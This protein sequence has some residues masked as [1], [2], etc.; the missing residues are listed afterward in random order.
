MKT[1]LVTGGAGYVGSHTV[2]ALKKESCKVVIYDNLVYGH[3][4]ATQYADDFIEGDLSDR[5]KLKKVF[6]RYVFDGVLHFAAYAYVGESVNNPSK[7]YQNNVVNSLNLLDMIIKNGIR[8]IVFSSSCTVYG[9][10]NEIPV[11]EGHPLNPISPYGKTKFM[12]EHILQDYQKAYGLNYAALRYFN[13]AGAD[14]EG[15][16]YED[17]TPETHLIPLIL[18]VASGEKEFL[19]IY[20]NDYPTADGSCVRDYVHVDD[21]ASAHI[22]ALNFL[23]K[24]PGGHIFNLGYGKGY[25]VKEIIEIA[26]KVTK[27]TI[28]VRIGPR[29]DGDPAA[30]IADNKKAL[31]ILSWSPQRDDIEMIVKSA[32]ENSQK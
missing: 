18:K 25:S 11:S 23:E 4:W 28:A 16:L 22:Q 32:W 14:A 13:A 15:E 7:Y 3:K 2:K 8:K 24:N 19:E 17:H 21:L 6:D 1:I 30:L 5:D 26:R 9:I 27:K 20:G 29:R 31:N 12:V 10:P